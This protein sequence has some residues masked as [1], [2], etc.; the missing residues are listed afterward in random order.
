MNKR[1]Q[2]SKYIVSDFIAATISWL[3]FNI[4]RYQELAVYEGFTS[5]SS[6]LSHYQVWHG[7]LLTP[8]FWLILFFLSGYY[9]KPFGKSRLTE[10]F[11]TFVT[12]AIGTVLIFFLIILND[13]PHSFTI[14][15][16][17]F[18]T[19][20][21]LQFFLTYI[22]RL[23]ITQIGINKIRKREWM[24][25]VLIIGTGEKALKIADDLYHL[26]Y[27]ISGFI[28]ED[29][30]ADIYVTPSRILGKLNDISG[31]VESQRIHELVIAVETSEDSKLM[32][33]LYSLY[34]YKRPIK[35]IAD[36]SNMLSRINIK[37]IHGMPLVVLTDNNFSE[38][39]KSIKWFLDK[40][41]S[42]FALIILSPFF[43]YISWRIK[44][45]S[46]GPVFFKQERIGYM[47]KPFMIYKFRT[48]YEGSE[49][50]GPLL[51]NEGDLRIT[52][53]GAIMRKY[54]IDELPQFWNVLKGDMSLVGPR[55]ERRYFIDQIV[56][57]APYYY[58]LHNVKPGITSLG[59]V[60]YGY[61]MDVDQMIE[62]LRYDILYYENMS[63]VLDLT[64]LIYTV[65]T[66]FTG[67]GI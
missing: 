10:L 12:V 47:G 24:Q 48:M 45:G 11:S 43:L 18:F 30:E 64:I 20:F 60:K 27:N 26:G 57:R 50:N 36:N 49:S 55:P 8:F 7:Q 17:L 4:L 63:L 51:A 34:R 1:K 41:I 52:P 54:R 46:A 23:V 6:Y 59:M 33:I 29:E 14:Y 40:C 16:E 9:N 38:A 66:V 13:L 56:K 53:F 42:I 37:T 25:N 22:P 58:L 28:S 3:L 21:G 39:E 19:L 2:T 31:I 65:K 62:R 5:L 32:P 15:Y 44:K 35:I 61:A 67:K